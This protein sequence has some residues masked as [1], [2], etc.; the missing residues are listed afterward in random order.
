MHAGQGVWNCCGLTQSVPVKVETVVGSGDAD[1]PVNSGTLLVDFV[2]E[3]VQ[4]SSAEGGGLDFLE[5][6]TFI[7]TLKRTAGGS[8][9]TENECSL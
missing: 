7:F 5:R 1:H 3:V 6:L 2:Q 4:N 8:L 9:V